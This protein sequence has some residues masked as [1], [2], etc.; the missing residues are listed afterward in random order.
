MSSPAVD[1]YYSL[2]GTILNAVTAPEGARESEIAA[3]WNKKA[4]GEE[5]LETIEGL[6]YVSKKLVFLRLPFLHLP[7]PPLL[8]SPPFSSLSP[9]L[10]SPLEASQGH[11]SFF[12]PLPSANREAPPLLRARCLCLAKSP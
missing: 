1:I 8:L 10:L 9:L 6:L 4:G 11:A 7:H 5:R 3:G 2:Y 12:P